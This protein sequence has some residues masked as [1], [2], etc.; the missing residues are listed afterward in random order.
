[1]RLLSTVRHALWSMFLL[2][3]C[4]HSSISL[5]Q[6]A[7]ATLQS[8][9]ERKAAPELALEDADGKQA[10][11]MDYRGKVVVLDFWATWCHGCQQE[12]P[13]F[14][15]FQ[16]EYG[17]KGLSVVG[18]SLDDEGWKV[19]RP[20]IKAAAVPYRIVLGNDSIAKAYAIGQM[21]DTF[22]IDREGRIAATYVGMVD[23]NDLETNI[24]KLL[25]QK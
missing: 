9:K 16:R 18:V 14:A 12:I 6:G 20:F 4:F 19:V 1:M 2:A 24:Q 21:P 15:G 17:N 5:A 3:F 22:L 23:K 11:L 25:A 8:A 13:W 10:K 7:S